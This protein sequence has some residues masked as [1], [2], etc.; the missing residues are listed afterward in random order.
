MVLATS[1]PIA[2]TSKKSVAIQKLTT[3]VDVKP[4][5][6]MAPIQASAP[7]VQRRRAPASVMT[8]TVCREWTVVTRLLFLW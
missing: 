4:N 3:G 7:P 2:D 5:S 8:E 6:P 1:Y